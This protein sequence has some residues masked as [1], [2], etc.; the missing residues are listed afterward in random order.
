VGDVLFIIGGIIPKRDFETL[1]KLGVRGIF[2]VHSTFDEIIQFI[3]ENV[4]PAQEVSA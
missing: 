1:K 3:R 4:S 2:S